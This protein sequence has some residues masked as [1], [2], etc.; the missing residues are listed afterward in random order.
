MSFGRPLG[1]CCRYCRQH[2]TGLALRTPG[3][4]LRCL[5]ARKPMDL[6]R[7]TPCRSSSSLR[8]HSARAEPRH[9]ER[10]PYTPQAAPTRRRAS[11]PGCRGA[12]AQCNAAGCIGSIGRAV[13]RRGSLVREHS[14]H[15]TA[16]QSQRAVFHGAVSFTAALVH[17]T[18]SS[19]ARSKDGRATKGR[20]M[21]WQRRLSLPIAVSGLPI[22]GA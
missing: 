15:R 10:G 21:T 17:E 18:R 22:H 4:P 16:A 19:S 14:A 2:C 5:R 13:A 8:A 7:V 20:T 3:S 11:G 1:Q 9:A 6:Y 12:R